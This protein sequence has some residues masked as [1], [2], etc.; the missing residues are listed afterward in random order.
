MRPQ[1][2]ISSANMRYAIISVD[3]AKIPTTRSYVTA[4]IW[5]RVEPY[6]LSTNN[7]LTFA[8]RWSLGDSKTTCF[9][10]VDFGR[11]WY[12]GTI[13]TNPRYLYNP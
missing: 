13:S 1:R 2:T 6:Y 4:Y 8:D 5:K 7:T 12:Y 9:N 3:L 10:L 11:F